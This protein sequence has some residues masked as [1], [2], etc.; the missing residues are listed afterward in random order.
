[1]MAKLPNYP[2]KKVP[3]AAQKQAEKK[4]TQRWM[5]LLKGQIHLA[6]EAAKRAK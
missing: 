2:Y 5:E 4:H 1:M 3:T 6:R